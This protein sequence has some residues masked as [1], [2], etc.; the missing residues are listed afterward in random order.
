MDEEVHGELGEGQ[1]DEVTSGEF[2]GGDKADWSLLR[3]RNS[4]LQLRSE[5]VDIAVNSLTKYKQNINDRA[6][7]EKSLYFQIY[8]CLL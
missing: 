3:H 8:F 2:P 6:E 4:S 5:Q 1:E 7:R